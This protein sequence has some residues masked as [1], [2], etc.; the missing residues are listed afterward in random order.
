MPYASCSI[1][2]YDRMKDNKVVVF[3]TGINWLISN[4]RAKITLDY[5]NRP[6]YTQKISGDIA[7]AVRRSCALLQLQIF[8]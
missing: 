4:H 7:K 2:D 6:T 8:I 1:A 3:N 5:Q